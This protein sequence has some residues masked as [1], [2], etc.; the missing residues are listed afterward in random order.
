NQKLQINYKKRFALVMA[1]YKKTTRK[2]Q[3]NYKKRGRLLID[4]KKTTDKLQSNYRITS[5]P[6]PEP[7][8]HRP[9]S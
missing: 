2:L 5:D 3:E 6:F 9:P 7:F 8:V 4:Y 1:D